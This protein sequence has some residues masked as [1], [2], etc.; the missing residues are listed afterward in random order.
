M[1]EYVTLRGEICVPYGVLQGRQASEVERLLCAQG[2]LPAAA[3]E[4][5]WRVAAE[6]SGYVLTYAF[7]LALGLQEE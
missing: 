5:R 1:T 4:K 2:V 6:Q 3:G 7:Q